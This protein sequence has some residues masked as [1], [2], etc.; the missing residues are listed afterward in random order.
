MIDKTILKTISMLYVEDEAEIREV[1]KSILESFVDTLVVAQDGQEGLDFFKKHNI[2]KTATKEFDVVITDINMPKL[3][4]LDMIE[5]IRKYDSKI[6]VIITTAHGDATFL[7][8]SI[9]LKVQG[10]VSKPLN[11][12]KLLD[13]IAYALE[14]KFLKEKLIK[15]NETLEAQ[16]E[17][18]T[19]ELR[20]ILNSQKNL[21]FVLNDDKISNINKT[22]LDFLGLENLEQFYDK[23]ICISNLFLEEEG[24]FHCTKNESWVLQ[25]QNLDPIDKIVK[26]YDKDK[27]IRYFQVDISNFFYNTEHYV[28]SFTDITELRN[29]TAKLD[30]QATHD[31]LTSLYNRQKLHSRLDGEIQR[32]KRYQREFALIMFDIDNFKSINDTY[33]HDVGDIV[34]K[35]ISDISKHSTRST[36]IVSRWGAEE[37]MILLPETSLEDAVTIAN[38]IRKAIEAY[39]FDQIDNPITISLGVT[40]FNWENDTKEHLLK[41]VDTA[42]YKAKETGKNKTVQI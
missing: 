4:G 2:D 10:Y 33:G 17:E 37:F 15:A 24:Y 40:I 14:P 31:N 6:P 36:D 42:L 28:I 30:Y 9:D 27:N 26:M 12:S 29:Y 11:L 35:I 32:Q 3:S 38:K 23:H 39:K 19:L 20:H 8:R 41:R 13:N 34:L 25:M 16:V 21:I 18:K 22:M 7:K 1:T 5:H